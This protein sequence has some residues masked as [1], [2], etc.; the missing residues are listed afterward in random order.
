[1]ISMLYFL[2]FDLLQEM[3][4][5]ESRLYPMKDGKNKCFMRFKDGKCN[6]LTISGTQLH[7]ISDETIWDKCH[8]LKI[9]L[10]SMNNLVKLPSGLES[11]KETVTLVCIQNNQFKDIPEILY[12]FSNLQHLSMHFNYVSSIPD[13]FKTLENLQRLYF[14]GNELNSLPDI[15]DSF[16]HLKIASFQ[17]NFLTSLPQ[18]FTK[19]DNLTNLNISHNKF[20]KFPKP[21][22]KLKSLEILDI[23][24]NRIQR[25]TPANENGNLYEDTHIFLKQLKSILLEGNPIKLHTRLKDIPDKDIRNALIED[26]VFRELSY[27]KPTYALRIN[28][29]GESGA[30]KTSVVQALAEGKYVIPTTEK[31]HRHTVGIDRYFM[32]FKMEDKVVQLHIWD[33]AGDNEY[34]MMNDL[35]I[36]SK[37]LIWIVVNLA[38]YPSPN[39]H[40]EIDPCYH[41]KKWLL[42]VMIHNTKPVFWII[43]THTDECHDYKLKED[44][45]RR[46]TEKLC[47]DF[48]ECLN[49]KIEKYKQLKKQ[50][51]ELEKLKNDNVPKFLL[52]HLQIIMLSNT[53]H[54]KGFENLKDRLGK[55]PNTSI[56][57]YLKDDFP[58]EWEEKIDELSLHR[59]DKKI[60]SPDRSDEL[61][62]YCHEIGEIYWMKQ[63][64]SLSNDNKRIVYPDVTHL[65]NL[66]KVIYRHG[67]FKE[68]IKE[69]NLRLD[70][71]D[72]FSDSEINE[73]FDRK[74]KSGII[75]ERFL[76]LMWNCQHN[77]SLFKNLI[78]LFEHYDLIYH[79]ESS[80]QESDYFFPYLVK[81]KHENFENCYKDSFIELQYEFKY[82]LPK[83]FLQRLAINLLRSKVNS[84]SEMFENGFKMLLPSGAKLYVTN[85]CE[86]DDKIRITAFPIN[87]KYVWEEISTAIE[88]IHL[89]LSSW[90]FDGHIGTIVMCPNCL[91]LKKEYPNF[92]ILLRIDETELSRHIGTKSF[93]CSTCKSSLCMD[94]MI[95]PYS[96][97]PLSQLLDNCTVVSDYRQFKD[98]IQERWVEK[99]EETTSETEYSSSYDAD[100]PDWSQHSEDL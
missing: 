38:K 75:P 10:F 23:R 45:I 13:R 70:M 55:L 2:D 73:C 83:F 65:I 63:P 25:L 26:Y 15:F 90:L 58:V 81:S 47:E 11:F 34:A 28:V 32:P 17:S 92:I 29:L 44:H 35:F 36:S 89:I 51:E 100:T 87:K 46:C 1:M 74:N 94:Q 18:S 62:K 80:E 96:Y 84:T 91:K 12:K 39:D 42:Q 20:T 4:L 3:V 85:V 67:D 82:Y 72:K 30:G 8:N 31:T 57:G 53:F 77:E 79:K 5:Y 41:I 95:L 54:F 86:S 43:G 69:L 22:L 97:N 14:G 68:R 40:T 19:L 59:K 27:I 71:H 49:N 24:Y 56:F 60:I 99:W 6:S 76:K 93:T 9:V 33:H 7:E 98:I 37:S 16:P 48:E 61:L 78:Q 88:Q 66:L 21:L 50:T 64:A 52:Q